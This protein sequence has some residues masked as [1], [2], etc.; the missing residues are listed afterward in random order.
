MK[1][2]ILEI[3]IL[4]PLFPLKSQSFLLERI[5]LYG[6]IRT[7]NHIILQELNLKKGKYFTE[8][9]IAKERAWLLRQ[10]FSKRVEF[11]TKPG[12]ALNSRILMIVVQEKS[13]WSVS[14]ILSNN[15]L[16]GWYVGTHLT[17]QNLFGRE[18]SIHVTFQVGG[19][20]NFALNWNN[21]W[22]GGRLHLFLGLNLNHTSFKYLYGDYFSHFREEVTNTDI[23]FGKEIGRR[24]KLGIKT[25]RERIWVAD[26]SVTYSKT[27]VDKINTFKF[28]TIFDSRDWPLYPRTGLYLKSWINWFNY[29]SKH[30]FERTGLNLCLYSPVYHDNIMALQTF[31]QISHGKVPV[32]KRIHLGGGKTI[33][34]YSTG[35][36]SGENSFLMSLEYRFPIF[37]ERNPLAGIHVGYVG[38]LFIDTGAAWF[39]HQKFRYSMLSSSFGLGFHVIWDHWILRAEYGNHGKGWGF[40]RLGSGVKF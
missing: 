22:F 40:I 7:K 3:F 18:N 6:N 24:F 34:G 8:K 33:R 31:L 10:N 28:F 5:A 12:S 2:I 23:T 37:Y 38:V 17:A 29:P 32:Y 36:F 13:P 39:Q 1:K 20:Q 16:F 11:Q 26:P 15:D 14:P 19:I 4:L 35:C 25:G 21:P 30:Q 9:F 27:H